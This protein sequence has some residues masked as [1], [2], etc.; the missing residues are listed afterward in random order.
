MTVEVTADASAVCRTVLKQLLEQDWASK[1]FGNLEQ[2]LSP[3]AA[4]ASQPEP[5]AAA[6]ADAGSTSLAAAAAGPVADGTHAVKPASL[7]Q[8]QYLHLL[9]ERCEVTCLLTQ[10]Y[11]GA[12]PATSPAIHDLDARRRAAD[13]D[14]DD[15]GAAAA[16]AAASAAAAA[17]FL[18]EL[19]GGLNWPTC[20]EERFVRLLQL[21][22]GSVYSAAAGFAAVTPS[23]GTSQA[24]VLQQLSEALAS[25]LI[26]AALQPAQLLQDLA[27]AAASGSHHRAP[28]LRAT[29]T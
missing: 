22:G 13:D 26:L 20:S 18:S 27:D 29:V 11:S 5:A 23:G 25:S 2:L 12:N 16:A 24:A 28:K 7:E 4:S 14:D 6:A 10:L 21:L 1:A 8:H 3:A 15:D 9:N 19:Q 17:Q